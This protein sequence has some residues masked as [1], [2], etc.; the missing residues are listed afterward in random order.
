MAISVYAALV[1]LLLFLAWYYA[2]IAAARHRAVRIL[3]QLE[4]ALAGEGHITDLQ[5]KS[6]ASFV[7]SLKLGSN[8]FRNA[9]VQVE[10][11]PRQSPWQWWRFARNRREETLNF[12]AD[13]EGAPGVEL[14]VVNRRWYGKPRRRKLLEERD[15]ELVGCRRFVLSSRSEWSHEISSLVN[16]LLVTR[17]QEVRQVG[18]SSSSPHFTA[19]FELSSLPQL[20]EQRPSVLDCLRELARQASAHH[21]DL[22]D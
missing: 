9:S 21:P 6:G 22:H 2:A 8:L 19:M 17:H 16:A 15:W 4:L 3:H 1:V 11:A 14:Q 12:C 7:T 10:M 20:A 13:L 18:F 5:W